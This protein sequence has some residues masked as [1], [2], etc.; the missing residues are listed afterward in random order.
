MTVSNGRHLLSIPGPTNVPDAVLQAMQRPAVD[1][2]SGE[3]IGITDACLND[4]A[5]IFRTRGRTYIYAANGHGGWEAALTNVLS[6]GDVALALESGRFA[7]GWG[8]MGKMLGVEVEVLPGGWRRAVDPAA[9]EERLRRDKGHAIKAI[10]VVQIDTASG[11]VNDVPAI[12]QAIDA[13]RH[14]ALLMVDAVA[15]LGCMP[16]EMDE[17]G[18]D[19]AMCGS[20][21]GL[22][23]PPGLAF[24][25]ANARARKAHE[26]AGLRTLYWDWSFREGEIHYQKYCGTPPEHLLFGLRK[27]LDLLLAEGLDAAIRRHA[28]LAEA[29]RAAVVR[30]AQAGAV[31]F[32]IENPADRA[33]SVTCVLAQGCDPRALHAYCRD[34]CGVTLG[35]GLGVLEGKAFRIAHMGHVNAPMVIGTLGAV[36]MG[37][38]ALGVPHGAGGVQAAVEYLG[39]EVAA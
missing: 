30:W 29:T 16:F 20:Q 34:K 22:M 35:V 18:V 19:V 26:A 24:V 15:S 6:R 5:S 28:L 25:A 33:N 23:T 4:L 32:N 7:I 12:R 3:M 27:A 11:V 17:W 9:L 10:L 14:P 2:Y 39:R 8:E 37:L 31:A 38:M 13:A 36:E 1:I 21:K